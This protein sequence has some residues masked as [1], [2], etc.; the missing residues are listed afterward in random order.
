MRIIFSG[1][2][3][4]QADHAD[5]EKREGDVM[6]CGDTAAGDGFNYSDSPVR[7]PVVDEQ[8][9]HER[10]HGAVA[11]ERYEEDDAEQESGESEDSYDSDYGL[12]GGRAISVERNSVDGLQG[13]IGFENGDKG[14]HGVHQR[15]ERKKPDG[16]FLPAIVIV[17]LLR[18]DSVEHEWHLGF[19]T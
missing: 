6:C 14:N 19:P 10:N 15:E 5:C 11:N 7:E 9:I 3:E 12:G 1:Q 8:D 17:E 2:G 16:N 18:E 4:D 13:A